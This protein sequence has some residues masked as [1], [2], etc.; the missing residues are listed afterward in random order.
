[1]ADA[2][3]LK[4]RSSAR[5]LVIR[6]NG[7][8]PGSLP[9]AEWAEREC[10][11]IAVEP[12]GD[13]DPDSIADA[14]FDYVL[15]FASADDGCDAQ[16]WK[17]RYTAQGKRALLSL[18]HWPRVPG[19][20]G[21]DWDAVFT[22][23]WGRFETPLALFLSER[24]IGYEDADLFGLL[25]QGHTVVHAADLD[26]ANDPIFLQRAPAV[27]VHFSLPDD[28]ARPWGRFALKKAADLADEMR[29]AADSDCDW[30]FSIGE[31]CRAGSPILIF[32]V[33]PEMAASKD[34]ANVDE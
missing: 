5:I 16:K 3:I 15:I 12:L 26:N 17:K 34:N 10:P 24:V 7:A 31:N 2:A 9:L 1:M 19:E 20:C 11:C 21:L 23:P 25:R 14:S 4:S 13:C 8:V 22:T 6:L 28:L 27:I 29:A 32:R 18:T 33:E 30:L